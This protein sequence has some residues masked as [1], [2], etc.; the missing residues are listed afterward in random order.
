MVGEGV[1]PSAQLMAAGLDSRGAMELR[2]RLGALSASCNFASIGRS[3]VCVGGMFS[4]LWSVMGQPDV[5]WK[6]R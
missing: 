4:H 2:H 1:S 5:H 3:S 6:R